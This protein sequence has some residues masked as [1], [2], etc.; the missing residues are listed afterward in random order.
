MKMR[1]TPTEIEAS[2]ILNIGEKKVKVSPPQIG[3]QL[4]RS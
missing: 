2:A 4:G 1:I 3:I